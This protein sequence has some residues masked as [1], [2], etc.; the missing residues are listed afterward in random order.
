MDS[1]IKR[2]LVGQFS[3][4]DLNWT[5]LIERWYRYRGGTVFFLLT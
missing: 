1:F 3:K 5:V 2:A 4:M